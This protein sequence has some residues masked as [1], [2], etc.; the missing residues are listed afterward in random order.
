VSS[1]SG[2]CVRFG[3]RDAPPPRHSIRHDHDAERADT[4]QAGRDARAVSGNPGGRPPV[5]P[6]V[7]VG[8]RALVVSLLAHIAAVAAIAHRGDATDPGRTAAHTDERAPVAIELVPPPAVQPLEVA[9]ISEATPAS[10]APGA[11]VLTASRAAVSGGGLASAG[12]PARGPDTG[13]SS[14]H[15]GALAMRGLRHDLSLPVDA[16]SRI[17]KDGVRA[18]PIKPSGKIHPDGGRSSIDDATASYTVHGDGTVDV[19]DK[20]DMEVHLEIHLPSRERI[21]AAMHAIGDDIDAWRA[22]PYRDTRVGATQDLPQ[23]LQAIPGSCQKVGDQMCSADVPHKTTQIVRDALIIPV[24][25]GKLDIAAYLQ[26]KYIGDPFASR[27]LKML[28]DTR[29]ER[30]AAGAVQRAEQLDRSAELMATHLEALWRT[31]SDPVARRRALFELWDECAEGDDAAGAAGD[32]ARV[33]VIGWI[34]AH[35]PAGEPGAFSADD[36]AALDAHRAS[37]QH[38]APYDTGPGR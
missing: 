10:R 28:D 26:R 36:I 27:K 3:H 31:T 34:R 18:E 6:A 20:P 16:M 30:A 11:S 29:A 9:V 24:I 21:R 15:T 2:E 23:H 13:I 12:E 19:V 17:L 37:R 25:T 8:S 1:W 22:D 35:L 32:R 7:T 4:G 14:P 33:M 38:F 5:T